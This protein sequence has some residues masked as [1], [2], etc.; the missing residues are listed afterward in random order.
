MIF[1]NWKFHHVGIATNSLETLATRMQDVSTGQ[2]LDF[3]DPAQG[4]RGRFLE[5]GNMNLEILEPLGDDNTLA[6]WLNDGNRV[7]QIAF[8]VDDLD[9]ELEIVRKKR[10]RIVRDA[11]QAVAFNGRRVAFLMPVPGLLIE[12]IEG[13]STQ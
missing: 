1:S 9:L 8:E 4:V 2:V 10:I 7:Y 12:L 13:T 11:Q 5:I 6:P 3:E